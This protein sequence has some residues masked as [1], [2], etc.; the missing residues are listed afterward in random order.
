MLPEDAL[1]NIISKN[2]D[3]IKE[4]I[5]EKEEESKKIKEEF[6]Q[7]LLNDEKFHKCTNASLR[8]TY[9][10]ELYKD[11]EHQNFKKAFIRGTDYQRHNEYDEFI[12]M[13]WR[14]YKESLKKKSHSPYLNYSEID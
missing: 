1:E 3:L 5:L 8:T 2:E 10:M 9:R 7:Y 14:E 13:V 6:H 12:E 4:Y 11:K